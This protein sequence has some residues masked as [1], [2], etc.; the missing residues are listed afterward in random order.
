MISKREKHSWEGRRT[1][2]ARSPAFS[3]E[4]VEFLSSIGNK[5]ASPSSRG[6]IM[7]APFIVLFA[8]LSPY[9]VCQTTTGTI[10]G[11]VT[12]ASSGESIV[13]A[14]VSIDNPPYITY[15]DS[16]GTYRLVRIRPGVYD[17][18][19]SAPGY[20]RLMFKGLMIP[21]Y[22][23]M[24]IDPH[25]RGAATSS[26]STIVVTFDAL[27]KPPAPSDERMKFYQPDSTIDYKIRIVNPEHMHKGRRTPAI[28]DS[29]ARH[30]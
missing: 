27:L 10:R 9:V 30:K 19:V 12:S 7:K 14:R 24:V 1:K 2:G 26:D 25:L 28:P 22:S 5:T 8:L 17:L 4:F 15:T 18:T 21:E 3:L 13:H 29:S 11:R 6:P 23:P 20:A 16:N